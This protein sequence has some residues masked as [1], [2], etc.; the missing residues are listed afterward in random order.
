VDVRSLRRAVVRR[1]VALRAWI[2]WSPRRAGTV[3]GVCLTV[4]L[5]A[6]VAAG[7]T[8]SAAGDSGSAEAATPAAVP[9]ASVQPT[10]TVQPG[11]DAPVVTATPSGPNDDDA[12]VSTAEQAA[13]ST[14]ALKFASLWLAGAFVPDRQR[15]ADSLT[16]LVD[17]SLRPFLEATPASAIPHTSVASAVPQLVAPSYG[18]VRVTFADRT[19]MDLQMSATGSTWRVVQYLPTATP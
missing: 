8:R 16:G 1:L 5:V 17:P 11:T 15:W 12:A 7:I 19:G 14:A 13:A 9:T 3:A 2:T 18:A 6:P 10:P 4:L